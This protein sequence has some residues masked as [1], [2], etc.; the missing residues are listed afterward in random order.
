GFK[1]RVQ[2]VWFQE[3]S[4]SATTLGIKVDAALRER[5]RNAAARIG[6]TQHWLIKQSIFAFLED[7]EAGRLPASL[8]HLAESDSDELKSLE[9]LGLI[10]ASSQAAQPFLEF[11]QS[12]APQSVLRAAITSA[13]R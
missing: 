9:E 10:A 2:P 5:I 7:I 1:L 8:V 12:V 3:S 11:A 6:R 4:M 13:Y